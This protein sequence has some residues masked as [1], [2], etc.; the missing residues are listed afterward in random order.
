MPRA[1]GFE[2]PRRDGAVVRHRRERVVLARPRDVR[3]A[4]VRQV[5]VRQVAHAP[6]PVTPGSAASPACSRRPNSLNASRSGI[7][8]P[9][10]RDAERQHP[11]GAEAADR[12]AASRRTIAS[13][14]PRRPAAP[15]SARSAARPAPNACGSACRRRIGGR[16]AAAPRSAASETPRRPARAKT[17]GPT[18]RRSPTVK[19]S[20]AGSI[21]AAP[22]RSR[23]SGRSARRNC[24]PQW[25]TSSPAP[26]PSA[27]SSR[28]STRHCRS[29]PCVAGAERHPQRRLARAA[30]RARDEQARDVDARDHQQNRHAAKQREQRR[31]D[32]PD[33]VGLQADGVVDAARGAVIGVL[34]GNLRRDAVDVAPRLRDA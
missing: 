13:S 29:E 16:P 28:P 22:S 6:T 11:I 26:A 14:A 9:R 19:A 12:P 34:A 8:R 3:A 30:G 25:P 27:A 18:R 31:T 17:A 1:D 7:P 23:L 21:R 10:Q 33:A 32:L 20:T 15:R 24:R 4:P 2:K 5:V